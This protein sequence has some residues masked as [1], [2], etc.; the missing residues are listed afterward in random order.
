MTHQPDPGIVRGIASS[1][2][3]TEIDTIRDLGAMDI[4]EQCEDELAHVADQYDDPAEANAAMD[5]LIAAVRADITAARITFTWDTASAAAPDRADGIESIG[6]QVAAENLRSGIDSVRSRMVGQRALSQPDA[7]VLLA[8]LDRARSFRLASPSTAVNP[9]V[10][11]PERVA[12]YLTARG[13]VR[14]PKDRNLWDLADGSETV[15]VHSVADAPDYAKRTGL[16]VSDLAS[17]YGTGEL[18][19]L[20][21]IEEAGHA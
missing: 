2:L 19:V 17:I 20:A 15:H 9:E 14:R 16:L 11:T 1:V 10:H 5:A 3:T 4:G 21:D 7:A 12:A 18:Q 13:W 8:Q 6:H